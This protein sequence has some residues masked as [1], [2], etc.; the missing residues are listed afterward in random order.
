MMTMNNE[1]VVK[2]FDAFESENFWKYSS[3]IS[4]LI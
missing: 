2:V 4:D 3:K 1:R